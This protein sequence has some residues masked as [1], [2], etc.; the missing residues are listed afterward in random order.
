MDPAGFEPTAPALQGQCSTGLSYRPEITA[1][2]TF[3]KKYNVLEKKNLVDFFLL[4]DVFLLLKKRKGG[5]P[6]AGS[7]TVTL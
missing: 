4:H 2:F 1:F 7:P 5:D 6:T 3:M